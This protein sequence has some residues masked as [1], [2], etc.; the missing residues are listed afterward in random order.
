M[1]R[2]AR[3]LVPKSQSGRAVEMITGTRCAP[4]WIPS[5]LLSS[6]S[7]VIGRPNYL[8]SGFVIYRIFRASLKQVYCRKANGIVVESGCLTQC[9]DAKETMSI[10]KTMKLREHINTHSGRSPH[11]C[12]SPLQNSKRHLSTGCADQS[13]TLRRPEPS[14]L[15]KPGSRGSFYAAFSVANFIAAS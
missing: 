6:S 13:F 10:Q 2:G 8:Q 14:Q 11:T 12:C 3:V 4:L 5:S 7:S 15:E 9:Q 1:R